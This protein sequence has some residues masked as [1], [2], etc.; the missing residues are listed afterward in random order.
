MKAISPKMEVRLNFLKLVRSDELNSVMREPDMT[1]EPVHQKL[2]ELF[3]FAG[4]ILFDSR[5]KHALAEIL[6]PHPAVLIWRFLSGDRPD[7]MLVSKHPGKVIFKDYSTGALYELRIQQ[8]IP[9][10]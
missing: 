4:R 2:D 8:L 7:P 3:A 6:P 10:P 1:T 9:S 5:N